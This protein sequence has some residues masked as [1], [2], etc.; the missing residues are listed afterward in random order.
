EIDW[1]FV[2]CSPVLQNAIQKACAGRATFHPPSW[3]ARSRLYGW[4]AMLYHHP[5]LPESFGRTCAEALRAGCIPIVD[6]RGG[7]SE[8]L[9]GTALA[10]AGCLCRTPEDFQPI[11][12]AIQD[13]AMR[14]TLS[15]TA[16]AVGDDRFSLAEFANRLRTEF[17]RLASP[18][19]D[20]LGS[21]VR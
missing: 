21:L 9:S 15:R 18:R 13:R 4:D 5:E 14:W 8:Q 7:F 11:L 10:E 12:A 20:R 6:D 17:H 2:G 3:E 1:E 19:D 16:R